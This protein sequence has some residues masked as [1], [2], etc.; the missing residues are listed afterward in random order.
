MK[1]EKRK[2]EEEKREKR[3]RKLEEMEAEEEEDLQNWL[4]QPLVGVVE[5]GKREE[6]KEGEGEGDTTEEEGD[7]TVVFNSPLAKGST[8]NDE[9]E[10]NPETSAVAA[11]SQSMDVD[12]NPST[13]LVDAPSPSKRPLFREYSSTFTLGDAH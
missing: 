13:P 9:M 4:V 5:G 6:G 1:V 10:V 2:A 11:G 12:T 7:P 3:K 8:H